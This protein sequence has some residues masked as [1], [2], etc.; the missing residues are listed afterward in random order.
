MPV[1]SQERE[2]AFVRTGTTH[3]TAVSGSNLALVA[4]ILATAGAATIGRHRGFWQAVTIGG[5]WGYALLTGGQPPSVRAAIVASAATLAIRF[6]R[7]ADFPTLIMLA[8]GAMALVDPRQVEGLGFRLSVA[9]SLA[10][11]LVLPGLI[12][13]GRGSYL[14][15]VIGAPVAAQIATLPFLLGTFGTLSL[16]SLPA[17]VLAVPLAAVAM[18]IT[19]VA[20]IIG[21][22]CSHGVRRSPR[23]LHLPRRYSIQ[24]VDALDQ[25]QGYVTVG[26]P[27]R[28]RSP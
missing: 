6:G 7:G 20:G 22:S 27:P 10:L 11:A 17:N 14:S 18:P 25:P 4:G 15:M 28:D 21:L 5:L 3:L 2:T 8:A 24:I 13:R 1:F 9:A 23:R 16:L 12:A 19:A 26:I